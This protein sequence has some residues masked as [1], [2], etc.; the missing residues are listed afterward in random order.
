MFSLDWIVFFLSSAI[1]LAAIYYKLKV[2]TL[3]QAVAV[4]LIIL[5][6][7][8]NKSI[9]SRTKKVMTTSSRLALLFFSSLIIQLIILSTGGFFS[10]FLILLHLYFLGISFLLNLQSS[11]IFLIF[12]VIILIANIWLSQDLLTLFKAD[13]FSFVLYFISFIVIIPL[14]QLL[15]HTYHIKDT[16]S[17]LMSENLYQGKLREKSILSGLKEL[18]LVTDKDLKI[19]SVNRAAEQIV[20]SVHDQI[21][22]KQ[23][24]D[25]LPLQY[26][27]GSK[28][29]IENLSIDQMLIDKTARIINDFVLVDKTNT[30]TEVTIQINPIT[31]LKKGIEQFVFVIKE[32]KFDASSVS[33]HKNLDQ[34]HKKMEAIFEDF[35]KN[36]SKTPL[37]SIN[38]KA[39]IL[40][41]IE[42]DI[43]ISQE[44]EDHPM[45]EVVSLLDIAEAAQEVVIKKQEFAKNLNVALQFMIPPEEMIEISRLKLKSQNIPL[46]K[47]SEISNFAAPIDPKWFAL[48]VEKILDISILLASGQKNSQVQLLVSP[49]SNN[50]IYISIVTTPIKIPQKSEGL[51]LTEYFGQLG[52]STNLRFG[53][54]L[55]GFIAQTIATNLKLPLTVRSEK[56][57][58]NLTF[59]LQILKDRVKGS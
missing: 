45:T 12:S 53:S 13:P 24:L 32:G 55:E 40:R 33:I 44:I 27:D 10:P 26:K 41:K 48:I 2:Q 36:L 59:M 21:I 49:E 6:F 50:I 30:Q 31:D 8:L 22:G 5:I 4:L 28:A 35:T 14:A 23:L 39:Q 38:L 16:I 56:Y 9:F 58:F 20:E 29:T 54:G 7:F 47:L 34:A 42:E 37:N 19:L 52:E 11:V 25:V 43:L 46:D 51:L 1:T 15:N 3:Q 57:P 18:V 17:R